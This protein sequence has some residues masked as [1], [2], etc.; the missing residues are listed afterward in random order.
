MSTLQDIKSLTQ[1]FVHS[2]DERREPLDQVAKVIQA[3]R[4]SLNSVPPFKDDP[5]AKVYLA[6]TML[7][8]LA[9]CIS[10][11]LTF[12][13]QEVHRA[14]ENVSGSSAKSCAPFSS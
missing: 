1:T 8:D 11:Q 2:I 10:K 3:L 4:D 13:N 5:Q 7:S 9:L 6:D 12:V 14:G